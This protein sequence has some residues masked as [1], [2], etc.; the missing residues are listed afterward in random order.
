MKKD[1]IFTFWESEKEM[2]EYIKMCIES[3]KK[4]LSNYEIVILNYSNLD[5]Y[6]GKDFYDRILFEKFTI[7]QQTCAIRAAVLEKHGGI[8]MDASTIVTSTDIEKLFDDKAELNIFEYRIACIKAKKHAKILKKWVR[9]IKF[10]LFKYK[11]FF[12]FYFK[13]FPYQTRNMLSWDYLSNRILK[14]LFKTKNKKL[15]NNISLVEAKSY[16]DILWDKEYN[17]K[18]FAKCLSDGFNHFYIK[19]DFSEY[20]KANNDGLIILNHW[21][22]PRKYITFTREE[23]LNQNNTLSKLLYDNI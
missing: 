4:H 7:F 22:M 17:H 6:I 8:W 9:G 18:R 1:T 23:I 5:E 16:P 13:Y 10:H 19:N 11:Y 20:A 15:L 2:P 3:W 21:W 12:D 14:K